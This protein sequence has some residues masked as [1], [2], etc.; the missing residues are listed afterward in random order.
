MVGAICPLW[1]FIFRLKEIEMPLP[2]VTTSEFN[3]D[4][5]D[6]IWSKILGTIPVKRGFPSVRKEAFVVTKIIIWIVFGR[7]TL[8]PVPRRFGQVAHQNVVPVDMITALH[9]EV[10]GHG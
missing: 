3:V 6:R 5:P 8:T 9:R 7:F 4:S 2:G 1:G 10:L